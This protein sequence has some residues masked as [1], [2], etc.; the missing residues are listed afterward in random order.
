LN[1]PYHCLGFSEKKLFL[2]FIAL[3]LYVLRVRPKTLFLHSFYPSLLGVGLVIFCP[4]TKI[5]SVRHHNQVHLLARNFKGITLDKLIAK[6]CFL[7]VAVSS[8]VR[9]TLIQQGCEPEKVL[10]IYNGI[11]LSQMVEKKPLT[12]SNNAKIH[13]IAAGRLDWQKN[14]ETMLL[15]ASELKKRSVDFQLSILGAGNSNYSESLFEMAKSLEIEDYVRWQGWQS[16]IEEWFNESD[17]L[18][19][20]A[21]DEACPLILIEALLAGLPIITSKAGGSGEVVSG[22]GIQC[23]PHDVSGYVDNILATWRNIN[24]VTSMARGQVPLVENKFGAVQMRKGYESCVISI[25]NSH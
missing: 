5:V 25:L 17:I 7:T 6:M 11:N 9:D 15:V 19:H 3:L 12:S 22:Y 16:N 10:V 18:L 14:Y 8:A 21:V 24:E 13:L 2:Q 20:T 4:F 23:N 1:I